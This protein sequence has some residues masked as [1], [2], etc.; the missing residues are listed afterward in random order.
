MGIPKA[1]AHLYPHK[2]Y[3]TK[4]L[5]TTCIQTGQI[6]SDKIIGEIATPKEHAFIN[7]RAAFLSFVDALQEAKQ[8]AQT[9]QA[10]DVYIEDDL[11]AFFVCKG[12]TAAQ[13]TVPRCDEL[14]NEIKERIYQQRQI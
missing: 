13:R 11:M 3:I 14:A 8:E 2:T 4:S 1:L 12:K 6:R 7:G 5:Q 10:K 9:F